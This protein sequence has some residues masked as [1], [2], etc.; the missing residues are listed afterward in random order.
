MQGLHKGMCLSGK[1]QCRAFVG[2]DKT[3]SI[4]VQDSKISR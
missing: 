2:V 1:Q 3:L 4:R